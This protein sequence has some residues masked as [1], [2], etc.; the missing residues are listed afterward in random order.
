MEDLLRMCGGMEHIVH[1]QNLELRRLQHM[2]G[3]LQASE[4]DPHTAEKK[5]ASLLQEIA[6]YEESIQNLHISLTKTQ[7]LMVSVLSD[8]ERNV[9][10]LRCFKGY[11][12]NVVARRATMCRSKC[13]K[14]YIVALNKMCKAWE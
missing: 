13:C 14:I 6:K 5:R 9:V 10:R 1:E 8:E 7:R 3:S 4:Y 11:R 2:L 12:W